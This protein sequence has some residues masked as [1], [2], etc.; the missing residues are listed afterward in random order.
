MIRNNRF[1]FYFFGLLSP[2]IFAI[3]WFFAG[4][5]FALSLGFIGSIFSFNY[6]NFLLFIFLIITFILFPG[7][8]INLLIKIHKHQ[9]K[10]FRERGGEIPKNIKSLISFWWIF[11]ITVSFVFVVTLFAPTPRGPAYASSVKNG[12]AQGVKEC[13]VRAADNQTTGF[14]DVQAFSGNYTKFI[15]ESLDPNSCYK[16]RA[17]PKDDSQTWFELDLNKV[18]GEVSKTCGDST[19]YG[20]SKGNTW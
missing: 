9:V 11:S 8:G 14:N 6:V 16:A 5:I 18:T 20:C 13:V 15:I 17:V 4:I 1:F 10:I 19:K 2:Y 3:A 7:L 12:L